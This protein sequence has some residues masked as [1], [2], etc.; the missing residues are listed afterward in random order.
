MVDDAAE[1][2]R[3]V[4]WRRSH[5]TASHEAM[6]ALARGTQRK[7]ARTACGYRPW[8]AFW[9]DR[10]NEY[11]EA[12][13]KLNPEPRAIVEAKHAEL[14]Q[15]IVPVPTSGGRLIALASRGDMS[16]MDVEP[17]TLTPSAES[18]AIF[19]STVE[20]P[21]VDL[22]RAS[23]DR[24]FEVSMP[25]EPTAAE[26]QAARQAEREVRLYMAADRTHHCVSPPTRVTL[27][28]MCSP[29]PANHAHIRVPC[30]DARSTR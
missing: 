1:R 19:G 29:P 3:A 9:G 13:E 17:S 21:R 10:V 12:L 5:Q 7:L 26:C 27:H 4:A 14:S 20:Y 18:L 6:T 24:P 22:T 25:H 8:R 11:T 16:C 28:M 30:S 2:T 15:A 23:F